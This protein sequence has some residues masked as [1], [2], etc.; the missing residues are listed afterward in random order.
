MAFSEFETKRL[1]KIVGAF[2]NE[3][4]PPPHVRSELDLGFRITGQSVDIFEIRPRW[5]GQPGEKVEGPVARATFVKA[6]EA[7]KVF[8]RRADLRWH[9]YP[10]KPRVP[11]IEK[12]LALVAEDKHACFFG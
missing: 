3:H 8:W 2:I 6:Q 11:S 12:F 1:E 10:P 4:R 9:P 7:W 5:R